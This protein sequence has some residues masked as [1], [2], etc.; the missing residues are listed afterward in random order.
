[1]P[2]PT[3]DHPPI[4]S[5]LGNRNRPRG[6]VDRCP[7]GRVPNARHAFLRD[8]DGWRLAP[9]FDLNPTPEKAEHSLAIDERNAEPSLDLVRE[10]APWYRI[11]RL[12][13]DEILGE[14]RSA[15]A[16]W[17]DIARELGLADHE[18]ALVGDVIATP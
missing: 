4:E 3:P 6:I 1:M 10:T 16:T 15:I 9:A 14:L 18:V 12:R 2:V 5:P 13:L 17:P 11:K 8:R 7:S